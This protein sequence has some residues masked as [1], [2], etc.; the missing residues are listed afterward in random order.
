M[1]PPNGDMWPL[2]V[3]PHNT[4]SAKFFHVSSKLQVSI[5]FSYKI[6]LRFWSCCWNFLDEIYDLM[7]VLMRFED[8][9]FWS[10]LDPLGSILLANEILG[11]QNHYQ[12]NGKW[13]KFSFTFSFSIHHDLLGC[14]PLKPTWKYSTSL[15]HEVLVLISRM[16]S[17]RNLTKYS[18]AKSST[19]GTWAL[20]F[21]SMITGG[22]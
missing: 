14:I 2:L 5:T 22:S 12:S 3:V 7:L 4:V 9:K 8:F 1:S 18:G 10:F 17:S 15:R 16:T 13:G 20:S 21:G 11:L 6:R 19:D